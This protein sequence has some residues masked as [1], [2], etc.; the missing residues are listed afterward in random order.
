M[1]LKALDASKFTVAPTPVD[2]W[3]AAGAGL[4]IIQ[5]HPANYGQERSLE[6][7]RAVHGAGMPFDSY[8]YQYLAYL[9]WLPGALVT[10]D[11]A[12]AEGL[13]PRKLWLDVEDVDSGKGWSVVQRVAAIQR[14]LDLCDTWATAHGLPR[15]GVYGASWYWHPYLANTVAFAD[16]QLWTAEY[17]NVADAAAFTEFGGWES[18]RIKQYAGSQPD[19][20]DLDV[21]SEDEEADLNGGDMTPVPQDY[22]DKFGPN[23]TWPGV[24]ANLEGII[25][26]VQ[27]ELA[28]AESTDAQ[29]KLD[30]IKVIV[31]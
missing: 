21:L 6:I 18:C 20:T 22:R 11:L 4:A 29:A 9:D 24:A 16:R 15:T 25:S 19:G 3:Q 10:L 14:D 13:L 8:I 30:K 31:G 28:A 1:T 17:D 23:V 12:A 26:Q 2:A 5:S 27:A 7:M